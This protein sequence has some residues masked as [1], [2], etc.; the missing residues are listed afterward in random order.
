MC[1]LCLCSPLGYRLMSLALNKTGR[2][3]VYSCEWPFYLRPVQQVRSASQG[4]AWGSR[5]KKRKPFKIAKQHPEQLAAL[6][7]DKEQGCKM[8]E[9]PFFFQSPEA[10][11]NHC[12]AETHSVGFCSMKAQPRWSV[13]KKP[14]HPSAPSLQ[15]AKQQTIGNADSQPSR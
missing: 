5:G 1:N 13:P 3:I 15:G 10:F 14:Q 8:E 9:K 12:S 7:S 6:C 4:L 2:S 11:P